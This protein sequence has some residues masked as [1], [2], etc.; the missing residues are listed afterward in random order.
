[1]QTGVYRFKAKNG[2]FMPVRSTSFSFRNP[3]TKDVE[4]IVSTNTFVPYVTPYLCLNKH[5][6]P[7]RYT[8]SLSQLTHLSRTLHPIFVS[9]NTF[10]PY[11]SPYLC[12]NKHICPVRYT[13]SLCQQTHLSR[14]LHPIFVSTNT[15]VPY[16]TPYLC[17]N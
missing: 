5:I 4:Y 1:M 6:C 2:Y 8:L 16:V 11:V 3:W 13:L 17:V 10:V 9:T 15:F 12:V 14:T 7:V